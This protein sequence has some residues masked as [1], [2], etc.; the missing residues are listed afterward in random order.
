MANHNS[1]FD[2]YDGL[3]L[4][5]LVRKKKVHPKELVEFSIKKIEKLNPELNAVIHTTFDQAN[6]LASSNKIPKGIFAGVPLLLKD[7]LH[8]V[9]GEPITNGSKAYRKFRA[10]QDSDFVSK[11]RGSGFIFLGTTN[12]PEFALMGIT[13]PQAYGPTRNPWDTERTPGGSSGGSASAVAS[14]MVPIATASDGGGSIRIPAAYCGLFGLKPTR[15]RVPVYPKGRVWQGASCDLVVTKTVRDTA[16][17]LDVASG[18]DRSEAFYLGPPN[19]SYLTDMKK[20]PGKLRI[21][22]SFTSPIGTGVNPDHVSGVMETV[23]LLKSLGHKLVPETPNIDGKKLAQS[24]VTMY[25]GEVASEIDHLKKT[26]GRKARMGDL[27]STTWILGVLGKSVPAGEF[28]NAMRTWD[29]AAYS[30]EEF[31]KSY[32][33][34]LTPTTAEPPA[35]IGELAPKLWEEIAMQIIGRLGLGKLLLASGMVDQLVEKNLSRTPFTQ[36][37]NLTGQP[38]MSVP[39]AKTQ[40]GLPIGMQFTAPRGREDLLLRLAAQLEKAKPWGKFKV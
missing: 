24:Y 20:S 27:E 1:D 31:H 33:L 8:E 11:L 34:Y 6:K 16:A 25:F 23:K 30:M 36:L 29:E 2:S 13:E 26:L 5:E 37:A 15:G 3:G 38:S 10:A 19:V 21:A 9:K 32:D 12:V 35:K 4:A 40:L 14:G 18:T 28:V 17:V 7:L 22:Y 39:L